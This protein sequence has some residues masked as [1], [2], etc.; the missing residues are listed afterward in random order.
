M[1]VNC[2]SCGRLVPRDKAVSYVRRVTYSTDLR[3]AEDIRVSEGRK[4]FYCPSC[5]KSR[6]VYEKKKRAAMRK[7]NI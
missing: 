5:G 6:G 7:Y 2:E 4:V 3:T 1:L